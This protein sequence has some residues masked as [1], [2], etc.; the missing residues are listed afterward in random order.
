MAYRKGRRAVRGRAGR[1]GYG[2]RRSSGYRA[3]GRAYSARGRRGVRAGARSAGGNRLRIEV[4]QV[5]QSLVQRPPETVGL[6]NK[7][8]PPNRK[9]F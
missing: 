7:V 5:P 2:G 9:S 4:V 8:T 1:R 6:M 3:S